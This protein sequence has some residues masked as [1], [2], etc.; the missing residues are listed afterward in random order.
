MRNPCLHQ[1]CRCSMAS[2]RCLGRRR[3]YRPRPTE[4]RLL[5]H[6]MR[7]NAA[8]LEGFCNQLSRNACPCRRDP[9]CNNVRWCTL[10]F[11]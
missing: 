6:L 11:A 9:M 8:L 1:H 10:Y 7:R 2:S 3:R 4:G 5:S